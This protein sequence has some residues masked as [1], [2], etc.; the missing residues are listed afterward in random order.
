[1]QQLATQRSKFQ[2]KI[3]FK[4]AN[5]Y[6][7]LKTTPTIAIAAR[8]F[9]DGHF[10]RLYKKCLKVF[11]DLIVTEVNYLPQNNEFKN[12]FQRYDSFRDFNRVLF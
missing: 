5:D 1:M 11:V 8:L 4:P 9:R 2:H 6:L 10:L 3:C 7:K 12:V